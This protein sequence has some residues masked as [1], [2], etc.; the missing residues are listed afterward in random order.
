MEK[1][2]YPRSLVVFGASITKMNLGQI[3]LLNNK[4]LGYEGKLYGVG[5]Q[6]GDVQGI[7]V[8]K[9]VADLPEIPD[10]AIFLTPAKT[11]PALM[12]AC[13][14]KGIRRIVIESGGFSRQSFSGKRGAESCRQIRHE[15]YRPELRRY[16]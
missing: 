4:Q 5:S 3:V 16:R 9:D 14:Q 6:A 10:V 8:Y 13:G 7:P 12:E 15:G 11:V 1:F 2:F